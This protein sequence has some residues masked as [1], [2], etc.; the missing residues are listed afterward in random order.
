MVKLVIM[1]T[2][3]VASGR[4]D[5][6]APVLMAHRRRC[7]SDEP[8]T[9]QFEVMLPRDDDTRMLIYEVYQDDGA[10]QGTVHRAVARR[11][12]RDGRQGRRDKVHAC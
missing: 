2:I 4:M 12:G 11:N 5:L 9:L 3:E 7:L 8:G 6:V 10:S 1:G